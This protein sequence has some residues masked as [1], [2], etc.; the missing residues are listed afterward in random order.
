M[1]VGAANLSWITRVS[2]GSAAAGSLMVTREILF[3]WIV[4]ELH[5]ELAPIVGGKGGGRP[6]MAQAAGGTEPAN[7]DKIFPALETLLTK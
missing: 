3:F 6:D 2:S 1:F 5:K 4:N 7:L